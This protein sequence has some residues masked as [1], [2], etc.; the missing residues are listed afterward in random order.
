MNVPDMA[1]VLNHL[2]RDPVVKV[3]CALTPLVSVLFWICS[4]MSFA[5]F[6]I[7]QHALLH[8]LWLHSS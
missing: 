2:R 1:K 8:A 7:C 4:M 5:F 3:S 6:G